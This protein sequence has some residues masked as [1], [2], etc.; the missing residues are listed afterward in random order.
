MSEYLKEILNKK[1][2]INILILAILILGIPLTINLVRHQ[3]ILFSKAATDSVQLV[4]NPCTSLVNSKKVLTCPTVAL[5]FVAPS[6]VDVIS[7][8]KLVSTVYAQETVS[9]Q[10]KGSK[11]WDQIDAELKLAQYDGDYDHS[12]TELDIYN[13]TSCAPSYC[14]DN[15]PGAPLPNANYIWKADCSH[16]CTQNSQCP[17]N[18]SDPSNVRSDTSN[19]CFGFGPTENE[20]RC[21]QLRYIG[22][23]G[24]NPSPTPTPSGSNSACSVGKVCTC[25][26][27]SAGSCNQCNGGWCNGGKCS[28]CSAGGV[29]PT[30]A[31]TSIPSVSP[32][33]GT[34]TSFVC[35]K[36]DYGPLTNKTQ[37]C[38]CAEQN[39]D[40]GS[41]ISQNCPQAPKSAVSLV[42]SP[43]PVTKT[44]D[45][46][47]DLTLSV[48]AP[49]NTQWGVFYQ[50]GASCTVSTCNLQGWTPIGNVGSGSG[51]VTWPTAAQNLQNV[52][53][54][55]HT[56]AVI[57]R[58]NTEVLAATDVNFI[59]GTQVPIQNIV[60]VRYAQ[61]A[62][63]M[64]NPNQ[65]REIAYQKGGVK[66]DITFIDQNIGTKNVFVE[67]IDDKG[68]AFRGS[69]YPFSIDLIGPTPA[70]SSF[71]CEV[72]L[73]N[74]SDLLFKFIGTN[75][76]NTQGI[77][78][79]VLKE[80]GSLTPENWTDKAVTARLKSPPVSATTV[81]TRYVAILTNSSGQK[82]QEQQ[83]LVGIT[84][85]ALGG[86]L[87][88]RAPRNFDQTDVDLT[89]IS[90]KDKTQKSAEK[91]TIDK[92]GNITNMKTKLKSGDSYIACIKAPLSVRRCSDPFTASSGTNILNIDLPIGD[93]NGDGNI[94][95]VDGSLLRGQWGPMTANK[96]CDVNRDGVCNSFEWSCMLHDF[97][98]SDKSLP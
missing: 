98:S 53:A 76:G 81:G 55:T 94:N 64:T 18:T 89:I 71:A 43:N 52:P 96:N 6:E 44:N 65:R 59:Q 72:D 97:N 49:S 4:D 82:S 79:V 27:A 19:W 28:T 40:T 38:A 11:T 8:Q 36:D 84:Q 12:Q 74:S 91:V 54:G 50:N 9:T 92:E 66:Q 85:I 70:V 30:I 69:P 90:D 1:N 16:Y 58:A 68:Q 39:H 35:T 78:T 25:K 23:G 93:L 29:S 80:G 15:P 87:F 37:W 95:S 21:M 60:K 57:N 56:F 83:C 17:P 3:Q 20:P 75:F 86:K 10:C 22:S 47:P 42:V 61:N 33:P 73:A 67:F 51:N 31:P 7:S 14:Q 34:G 48:S 77:G 62:S 88:C 32:T 2:I 45:K 63:D 24:A 26:D 46:W 13:K 5:N 41:L